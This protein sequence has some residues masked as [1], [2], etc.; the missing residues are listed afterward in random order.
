MSMDFD[1]AW[2]GFM[3]PKRLARRICNDPKEKAARRARHAAFLCFN[4]L[5]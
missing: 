3:R 5:N 1:G 2:L 4:Q